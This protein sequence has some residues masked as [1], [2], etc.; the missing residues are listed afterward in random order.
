MTGKNRMEKDQTEIGHRIFEI[1]LALG[2]KS[3]RDFAKKIGISKVAVGQWFKGQVEPDPKHLLN[4]MKVFPE[5]NKNFLLFGHRPVFESSTSKEHTVLI[6]RIKTLERENER[7]REIIANLTN[8][9]EVLYKFY[10]V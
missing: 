4:L 6:R 7:L 8:T 9:V 10:Q 5:I 2:Y 3:H 1:Y